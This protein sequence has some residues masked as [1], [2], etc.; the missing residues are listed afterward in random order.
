MPVATDAPAH[1]YMTAEI[2]H[3]PNDAKWHRLH[4]DLLDS[5]LG[6]YIRR[7]INEFQP[8]DHD[9]AREMGAWLRDVAE[10]VSSEQDTH[11]FCTPSDMLGFFAAQIETVEFSH[12]V[13]PIIELRAKIRER[14]PQP[15]LLITAI[16][17]HA[18]ETQS[19]FGHVLFD[20]AVAE[21]L[22]KGAVAVV[23]EPANPAVRALWTERYAMSPLATPDGRELLW[24]PT[25]PAPEASW[26]S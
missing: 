15:A 21:A 13:W 19:G 6:G 14:Q 1:R 3:V 11:A 18:G 12:S 23:V 25:S 16:A 20:Y 7:L 5:G 2:P 8:L 24:F 4:R 26:P 17:R 9:A 10:G 22:S